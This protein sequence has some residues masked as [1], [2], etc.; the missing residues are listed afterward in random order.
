M[1][2]EELFVE[3]YRRGV[4]LSVVGADL[5]YRPPQDAMTPEM[6]AVIKA[7]KPALIVL[8]TPDDSLPDVIHYPRDLPNTDAAFRAHYQ[9][10]LK[11]SAA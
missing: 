9:S 10:Q 7:H 6:L 11:R 4:R 3:L 8:L 5:R 1:T 2:A